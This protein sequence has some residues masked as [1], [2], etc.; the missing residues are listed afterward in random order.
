MIV[1]N[2]TLYSNNKKINLKLEIL[3]KSNGNRINKYLLKEDIKKK[4][5]L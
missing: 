3:I 4:S 2:Y 1:K 5:T